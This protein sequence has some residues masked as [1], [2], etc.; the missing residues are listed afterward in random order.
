MARRFKHLSHLMTSNT[1]CTND[2]IWQEIQEKAALAGRKVYFFQEVD[3]TNT[4]AFDLGKE[5]KPHGTLVVAE[6]QTKGRGRLGRKWESPPGTGIYC[7]IIL[8][9][10]LAPEDLPKITLAAGVAV[11]KAVEKK[12]NLAPLIKWPNDILLAGKKLGGILTETGNFMYGEPP[13]VVLGIGLNINSDLSGFPTALSGKITSLK[14]QTGRQY[15]RGSFLKAI[16]NEIE[17]NL[18]E[19]QKNNFH[20][21]IR[22]FRKRDAVSG[23]LLSWV[24]IK[25]D[26]TTGVSLGID[27]HGLLHIKDE[28]GTIHEIMSGDITLAK[29]K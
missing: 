13:L 5:G 1:L 26:I 28:Q 14:I 25:G 6:S 3:S 17:K 23:K 12:T 19:L 15:S 4:I 24:T 8:R 27:D 22:Q 11:C 21:I 2:R 9:P 29:K 16:I 20:K 10:E 18:T 7:S